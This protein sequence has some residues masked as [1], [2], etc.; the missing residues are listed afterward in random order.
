MLQTRI[1]RI[2]SQLKI[3]LDASKMMTCYW[4]ED[5]VTNFYK[6][7]TTDRAQVVKLSNL[8]NAEIAVERFKCDRGLSFGNTLRYL[9]QFGLT[10]KSCTSNITTENMD[11][12]HCRDLVGSEF[13]VCFNDR[14]ESVLNFRALVSYELGSINDVKCEL[15]A[16]GPV[17]VGVL[18]GPRFMTDWDGLTPYDGTNDYPNDDGHAMTIIGWYTDKKTFDTI[19]IVQNTWGTSFGDKGFGLLSQRTPNLYYGGALPL[20]GNIDESNMYK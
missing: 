11:V 14:N 6:L 5:D 3:E 7:S 9:Y 18:H 13:N 12:I 2:A 20:L 16:I 8:S 4:S 19:W 15:I 1:N 10:T 17:V